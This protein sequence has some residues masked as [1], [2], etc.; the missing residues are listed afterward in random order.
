[1]KWT[2][3]EFIREACA[4]GFTQA[5]AEFRWSFLGDVTGPVTRRASGQ[6]S[7]VRKEIMTDI[8]ALAEAKEPCPTCIT[9][10]TPGWM[11]MEG[12]DGEPCP[13]CQNAEFL[14]GTGLKG[15]ALPSVPMPVLPEGLTD[16]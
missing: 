8:E 2:H 11:M 5:Q 3:I 1:M 7:G 14:G 4:V 13:D 16:E 10:P 9:S 6:R 15:G 12:H